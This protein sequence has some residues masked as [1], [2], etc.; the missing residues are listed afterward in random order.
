M[1]SSSFDA[2]SIESIVGILL[3]TKRKGNCY[4]RLQMSVFS[5]FFILFAFMHTNTRFFF[6]TLVRVKVQQQNQRQPW[7]IPSC[8]QKRDFQ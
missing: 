6:F 3:K 7:Q 1:A 8:G 5:Q 4:F 2:I